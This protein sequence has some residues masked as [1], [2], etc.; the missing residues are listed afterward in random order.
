[1]Y[2]WDLVYVPLTKAAEDG[3]TIKERL[4]LVEEAI[5]IAKKECG[6]GSDGII[7]MEEWL[8]HLKL[9]LG[10]P[11]D[12]MKKWNEKVQVLNG[13]ESGEKVRK[14]YSVAYKEFINPIQN[15]LIAAGKE[16]LTIKERLDLIGEMKITVNEN[17]R[18]DPEESKS[19]INSLEELETHLK[20]LLEKENMKVLLK[21]Y[22]EA[23][24]T[25]KEV[26]F[27]VAFEEYLST[28]PQTHK[29][30]DV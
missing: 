30:I 3:L 22:V 2:G 8:E 11:N 17:W 10:A 5:K 15:Q 24:N 20:G 18:D 9:F 28:P 19:N 25:P 6:H 21:W 13:R 23:H 29:I 14:V 16:G 4:K 1:M 7:Y 12:E 27:I 26:I